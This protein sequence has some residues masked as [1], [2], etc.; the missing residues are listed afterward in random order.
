MF[1]IDLITI[2]VF[3]MHVQDIAM[4]WHLIVIRAEGDVTFYIHNVE[5][6]MEWNEEDYV[7]KSGR[8]LRY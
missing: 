2:T 6:K 4:Q 1:S 8:D 7:I 5:A 3:I